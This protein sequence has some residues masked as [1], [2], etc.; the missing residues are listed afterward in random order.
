MS[1]EKLVIGDNDNGFDTENA[2]NQSRELVADL[3]M[4]EAV[5]KLDDDGNEMVDEAGHPVFE[6]KDLFLAAPPQMNEDGSMVLV[7]MNAPDS[8]DVI[9]HTVLSGYMKAEEIF[10][11]QVEQDSGL[12][13][14]D[15]QKLSSDNTGKIIGVD[16]GIIS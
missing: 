15:G 7:C 10:N 6:Q 12:V 2:H 8:E 13:G 16:G 14:L 1:D 4:K 3:L 11:P 5:I 9:V